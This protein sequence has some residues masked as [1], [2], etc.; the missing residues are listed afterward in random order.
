MHPD[1]LEPE[2]REALEPTVREACRGDNSGQNDVGLVV[3]LP[4]IP[5]KQGNVFTCKSI[6]NECSIDPKAA[7]SCLRLRALPGTA[8]YELDGQPIRETVL[9]PSGDD[10]AV[11]PDEQVANF[12]D[13]LRHGGLGSARSSSL[14]SG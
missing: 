11:R 1:S 8:E 13:P 10:T 4:P 14:L 7:R 2:G 12:S 5:V 6:R 9:H 3:Q